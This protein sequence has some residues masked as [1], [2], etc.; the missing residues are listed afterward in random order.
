ME[1]KGQCQG[2]AFSRKQEG[3][4][5]TPEPTFEEVL[6][7]AK[8]LTPVQKLRLIEAIVPDLA[9]PLN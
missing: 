4:M 1:A 3:I 2:L 5:I 7:L 6:N 9:E 8:Q